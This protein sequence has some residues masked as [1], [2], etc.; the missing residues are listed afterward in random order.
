MTNQD[1]PRRRI[2]PREREN[3][4][5]RG[6]GKAL[7]AGSGGGD[8][9]SRAAGGGS[10]AG[11]FPLLRLVAFRLCLC[12]LGGCAAAGKPAPPPQFPPEPTYPP[13]HAFVLD[14][15]IELSIHRNASLDVARYEALAARGIVDQVKSLWLPLIHYGFAAVVYDNDFS[16]RARVL[17]LVTVNVP[18]TGNYNLEHSLNISQI[19]TSGGKRTS[20]LKQ[21]RIY[22]A[23]QKLQ[24]LV[25]QDAVA[26]DVANN[27]YLVCLTNDI[28][29][30]LEDTLYRIHV[31]RRAS[32][33]LNARGSLRGNRIETL[34]SEYLTL[35]LDQLRIA[36]QAGRQQ[37]YEA[38]KHS[39]GLSRDEPLLLRDVT[40]PPPITLREAVSVSAMIVKGFLGRPEGRQADLLAHLGREQVRFAK[41][42][43]APNVALAGSYIA[44]QGNQYSVL[45]QIDGLLASLIVDVPLYYPGGR[46]ALLQSL[47]LEQASLALQ[48]E[49]E[50]LITLEINV[51]AID[52]QKALATVFKTARACQVAAEHERASRRA[53]SRNLIPASGVVAGILLDGLARVQHLQALYVYHSTRAK[54]NRVTAN[55][56]VRYGS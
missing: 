10:I 53:Y 12:G 4:R 51:T 54:L 21:A 11:F 48:R 32:G 9:A 28:D 29:R 52:A 3:T 19:V 31:F 49:V 45:G 46:A 47:G 15:L 33:D 14:E 18:I 42:A 16:Y 38:L 41:T 56:E 2:P 23:I 26:F 35:Q 27:Y 43:F 39:V 8:P 1:E 50:Q 7:P 24:I 36:A 13:G 5:K 40:L 25:R 20:A 34:E 44:G 6:S 55:R 37:A 30:V 22:E 17:K